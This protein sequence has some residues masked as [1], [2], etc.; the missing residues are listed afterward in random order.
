MGLKW[1]RGLAAAIVML[2]SPPAS[3]ASD[4]ITLHCSNMNNNQNRSAP[5]HLNILVRRD[6]SALTQ[7]PDKDNIVDRDLEE[8]GESHWT[9]NATGGGVVYSFYFQRMLLV[10]KQP[11]RYVSELACFPTTNPFVK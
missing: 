1:A 2:L 4:W 7:F 9:Y 5:L 10:A 6:G 3:A 11:M 8:S